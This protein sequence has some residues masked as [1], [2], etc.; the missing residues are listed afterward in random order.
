MTC[1]PIVYIVAEN[2]PHRAM[3]ERLLSEEGM[4]WRSFSTGQ[5]FLAGYDPDSAGC[6]ILDYSLPGMDGLEVQ[7][8]LA[9]RGRPVPIIM[10]TDSANVTIATKAMRSGAVDV[11][12]QPS[13]PAVL[14]QRVREALGEQANRRER[15]AR[16]RMASR[17]LEVLSPREHQ[18]M[19]LLVAGKNTKQIAL[20]LNLSVKT[21]HIHRAR[22]L[23]KTGC[24]SVVGLIKLA[25]EAGEVNVP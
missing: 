1:T 24:D 18:V 5:A 19:R 10:V 7:Q 14:L 13:D 3:V 21:V 6:L 17:Q 12:E 20:Q 2:S 23:E 25:A 15:L 16:R 8:I 4:A 11:L 22:V 9:S